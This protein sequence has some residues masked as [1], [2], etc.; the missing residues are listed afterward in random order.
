MENHAT[1]ILSAV[2]TKDIPAFG[3]ESW[4]QHSHPHFIKTP[5]S[6]NP[7]KEEAMALI[8]AKMP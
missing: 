4:A 8:W 2:L 7:G 3:V 1:R 5:S 6:R